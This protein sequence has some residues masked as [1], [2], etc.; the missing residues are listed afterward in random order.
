MLLRE[1]ISKE[2]ELIDLVPGIDEALEIR[3]ETL[4]ELDEQLEDI[5]DGEEPCR[6]NVEEND[7]GSY[8]LEDDSPPEKRWIA[9]ST[10]PTNDYMARLSP[11]Y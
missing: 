1:L 11:N 7:D 9:T 8:D 6:V 10:S 4:I 2:L 5:E 3:Q